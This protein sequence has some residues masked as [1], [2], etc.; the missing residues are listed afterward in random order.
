LFYKD[1][2]DFQSGGKKKMKIGLIRGISLCVLAILLIIPTC[3]PVHS[4][5]TLEGQFNM[6]LDGPDITEGLKTTGPV[7]VLENANPWSYN[8]VEDI[9]N[10]WIVMDLDV[11]P[12]SSFG[13][14]DLSYYHKVIIS[15]VQTGAFYDALE[16]NRTW[17][18]SYVIQGGILEI[19]AA[20]YVS[21][22][23]WILPF[24]FGLVWNNTDN[25]E[26][27]DPT[28]YVL[29]YPNTINA[30]DLDNWDSSAH[31]YFNNTEGATIILTDGA[32]EPVLI[33]QRFGRGY[34]IATTQ[35]VEWAYGHNAYADFLENLVWYAQ[36]TFSTPDEVLTGPIAVI[37]D[38]NAWGYTGANATQEILV[39][40][41]ISYDIIGSA[42]LGT[43]DLS[44]YQKVIISAS[45]E[46]YFYT[47]LEGNR[48]WL[49]DYVSNGGVLEV[50]AATQG[51]NWVLPGSMTF[52]YS[53][54]DNIVAQDPF[55]PT[56]YSPYWIRAP[57]LKFYWWSSHGYLNNTGDADIILTNG[58]NPIFV[59]K[60]F[61]AGVILASGQT[62]EYCW[63]YN[64]T[65]VLENL[66]LYM[67]GIVS[68]AMGPRPSDVTLEFGTTGH[69]LSWSPVDPRFVG[70]NVT[71]N[72]N[73]LEGDNWAGDAISVSLDGL[74]VGTYVFTCKMWDYPMRT[75]QDTVLVMVQDTT[76]PSFDE[77][78][79]DQSIGVGSDFTYDVNA[80]DLSGVDHWWIS[81]TDNFGISSTG[82]ITNTVP[83]QAGV[84]ELEVRAYDPYDNYGSTTFTLTVVAPFPF[85]IA[86]IAGVAVVGVVIIVVVMQRMK[87][88]GGAK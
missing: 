52:N 1:I 69:T 22:A 85:E 74:A 9:L 41:G 43:A 16:A 44:G 3:T 26:V 72:G 84:Y 88:S 11:I 35:P 17:I 27:A 63:H 18:E 21:E 47:A 80:S 67:P 14:V 70:Y 73:L 10:S 32:G 77:P 87:K 45:Q 83:L 29:N 20:T 6:A 71:R 38:T 59:E 39:K 42:L 58:V 53:T 25:V 62:L 46:T 15:S 30:M 82:I 79:T 13:A 65:R 48:T 64:Y 49:E 51:E 2:G 66:I 81:D 37:Q 12:S 55:H 24:G 36:T 23:G 61:G 56:L 5:P 54:S 7:A 50:H 34:V 76:G 75:I 33:E 28:H 31:S 68:P 57:E 8:S 60:Q 86:L 19:N 4:Q 78:V 40:Y